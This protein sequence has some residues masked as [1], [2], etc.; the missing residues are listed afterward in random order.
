MNRRNEILSSL[1]L[2]IIVVIIT[3]GG[4]QWYR[5]GKDIEEIRVRDA[6]MVIGTD[7]NLAETVNLLES[8]LQARIEYQ[9]DTKV[10]PLDLTRVITS[11][12]LLEKMGMDEFERTKT[13]MR[14]A[15]TIVGA[16]NV[17]A[18]V[19][20]YM[21][22]NHVLRIGDKIAGW[23][24]AEIGQK[25]VSLRK[26]SRTKKL[27]NE[28]APESVADGGLQMSVSPATTNGKY[29]ATVP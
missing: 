9:F 7:E 2:L 6:R 18:I 21:G 24:V 17:A 4:L 5:V 8:E 26:G 1:L 11:K 15:A 25:T 20:R 14:L 29:C 13:T 27:V 16:D 19:I 12:A 3:V 28:R 10:D 23:E 22:S